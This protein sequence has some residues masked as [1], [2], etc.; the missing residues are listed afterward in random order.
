MD[1]EKEYFFY[2]LY[3]F[4]FHFIIRQ[5]NRIKILTVTFIKRI[6]LLNTRLQNKGSCNLKN[7]IQGKVMICI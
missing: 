1:N 7:Y 4:F 3:I 6:K 5:Y 2:A